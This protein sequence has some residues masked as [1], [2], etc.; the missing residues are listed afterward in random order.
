MD[1]EVELSIKRMENELIAAR[2]LFFLS[3]LAEA[4]TLLKVPSRETFYSSAIGHAYYAIFYGAKAYLIKKG[5]K[6]SEQGQHQAVY[7]AFRKFVRQGKIAAEL[8]E[9]YEEVKVKADMLLEILEKEEENRT[10]FTYKTLA[11]ANKAPADESIKNAEIFLN[12]IK[13]LIGKN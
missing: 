10:K 3:E 1:S 4:K 11:Q 6:F 2:A 9:L 5:M 7:Y 8:L 12:E 13:G